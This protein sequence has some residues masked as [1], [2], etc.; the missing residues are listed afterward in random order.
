MGQNSSKEE[1]SDYSSREFFARQVELYRWRAD[2]LV[3][4]HISRVS[5]QHQASLRD[6]ERLRDVLKAD[7]IPLNELMA[8]AGDA[9]GGEQLM[10]F[11][12]YLCTLAD[13]AERL[14]LQ[15]VLYVLLAMFGGF[16]T[17]LGKLGRCRADLLSCFVTKE[18]EVRVW[19]G[20]D[21]RSN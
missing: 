9:R 10:S 3:N 12:Q 17:L 16:E 18:G 7:Q 1:W 6:R 14:T 19:L 8:L 4:T 20:P 21:Y 15:Q 2:P 11:E 5:F 13:L